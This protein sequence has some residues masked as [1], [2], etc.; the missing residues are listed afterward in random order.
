MALKNPWEMASFEDD[1]LAYVAKG[2]DED[3][4]EGDEK[5]KDDNEIDSRTFYQPPPGDSDP[6]YTFTDDVT[7]EVVTVTAPANDVNE[8]TTSQKTQTDTETKVE[9]I[10]TYYYLGWV[11]E[12]IRHAANTN[13]KKENMNIEF[14]YE[15]IVQ[16]DPVEIV[17]QRFFSEEPN[18]NIAM[19]KKID[20]VF[21]IPLNKNYVD[22]IIRDKEVS[23][24]GL[25]RGVIDTDSMP[26]PG[27]QLGISAKNN[28]IRLFLANVRLD[29]AIFEIEHDF[30]NIVTG[31][32]TL[33]DKILIASFGDKQSLVE[34]V[35]MTSKLDANA[36]VTYR[37]PISLAGST[38]NILKTGSEP[39]VMAKLRAE[40]G[41]EIT[42]IIGEIKE[43]EKEKGTPE[44]QIKITS[45]SITDRLIASDARNYKRILTTLLGKVDLFSRLLGFYL[46]RTTIQLHG[47]V[48]INAYNIFLL[49]GL[50]KQLEGIYTVLEVTEQ[51]NKDSFTT[52]IEAHLKNPFRKGFFNNQ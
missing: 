11:L 36:H 3:D 8:L 46:R 33:K 16:N 30:K 35:D 44:D 32:D 24:L 41:S 42:D 4:R 20:N 25:I 1:A 40:F 38:E 22:S 29:G 50:I 49:T 19:S 34:S 27:L 7:N 28:T 31:N 21:K 37:L 45:L 39:E 2:N 23:V 13:N 12:A 6:T 10:P 15:N 47:T 51:I 26:I 18:R 9:L 43:E 52:I 14:I 48:G 17:L 5:K